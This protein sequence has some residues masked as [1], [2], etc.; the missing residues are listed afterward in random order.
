MNVRL[1]SRRDSPRLARLHSVCSAKQPGGFMYGL[2]TPFLTEYYRV[3]IDEGS[4]VVLCAVDN[5]GQV[6]GFVAGA[7]D[8]KTR[9]AA[10]KRNRGRLLIAAL[11]ALVRR[12]QLVR[13]VY[14]RQTYNSVD[15]SGL[16]YVVQTGAHE[17][18]WA[19][20]PDHGGGAIELHLKWLAMMRL[21]GAG[22]I[23]GEVDKVNVAIVRVH[24]ILGAR[25]VKE[26]STPDGRQ[27]L[28]IEYP[29]QKLGLVGRGLPRAKI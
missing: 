14:R 2:G 24:R 1:A 13:E 22:S 21:L 17:E 15:N 11:P 6:I 5:S 26:F 8:A 3:L 9:L 10:L 28:V 27:R 19:W 25:V 7:L 16:G 4:S 12:P 20:L 23:T 18:F 29:A